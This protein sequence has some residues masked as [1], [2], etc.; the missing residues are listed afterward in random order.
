[1]LVCRKIIIEN[2]LLIT[3]FHMQ[4]LEISLKVMNNTPRRRPDA[5]IAHNSLQNYPSATWL[6]YT[7]L[8]LVSINQ[9]TFEVL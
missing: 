3:S 7:Q 2:V 6:Q 4:E 8:G 5:V 1:M 9:K